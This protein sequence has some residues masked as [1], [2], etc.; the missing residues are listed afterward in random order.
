MKEQGNRSFSAGLDRTLVFGILTASLF[1]FLVME[2]M[3]VDS[4]VTRS[5]V[6]YIGYI[7]GEG[8]SD[9]ILLAGH[10]WYTC[11]F[12]FVDWIESV[13][14]AMVKMGYGTTVQELFEFTPSTE[15]LTNLDT[16]GLVDV[17]DPLIVLQRGVNLT[18]TFK[19]WVHLNWSHDPIVE[20]TPEIWSNG[21]GLELDSANLLRFEIHGK[22]EPLTDRIMVID[23]LGRQVGT[24]EAVL[25]GSVVSVTGISFQYDDITDRFSG[26]Q[27]FTSENSPIVGYGD[28]RFNTT[29]KGSGYLAEVIISE[30]ETGT[31]DLTI[32]IPEIRDEWLYSLETWTFSID[33]D[34]LGPKIDMIKPAKNQQ[35]GDVE[36]EWNVTVTDRPVQSGVLVNGS[37]AQYRVWTRAGNWTD[38]N[39]VVEKENARSVFFTGNAIGEPGKDSTMVQFRVKDELGNLNISIE[40]PVHINVAPVIH[41]SAEN[42]DM[43]LMDNQSLNLDGSEFASDEDGDN[44]QYEWYLDDS[45]ALSTL[46]DFRKPLFDVEPGLHTVRIVV[47]DG[48]VKVE[49]SFEINVTMAPVEIDERSII[50]KFMDDENFYLIVIPVAVLLVFIPMVIIIILI[51]KKSRDRRRDDFIIDEDRSMDRSQAEDTARRIL[52]NMT[53]A[54][55]AEL[56]MGAEAVIETEG[57]DFDYDLYEVIGLDQT[58]TEVEIKKKYRKLAAFY[59]PDTVALNGQ[60]SKEDAREHMVKINKVKEVLLDLEVRERYDEYVSDSDFDMDIGDL[61]DEEDDDL[62]N[63]WD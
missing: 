5:N 3:N 9:D 53:E 59:H 49:A 55:E 16:S 61:H 30:L 43:E 31:I 20:L 29:F 7:D 36:F 25:S 58:A 39:D 4:E 57:F 6:D 26:L 38:W 21:T 22:L 45:D 44:L 35:L 33:I 28:I 42:I 50:E 13:D 24:G 46:K 47:F 51:S 41:I 52:Q 10:R 63:E 56:E 11:N 23:S 62:E 37:T 14:R 34:G 48:F 8:D 40:F 60:I 18:L 1:L 54:Q 19:I 32:D 17:K 15:E 27:P 2:G 12:T